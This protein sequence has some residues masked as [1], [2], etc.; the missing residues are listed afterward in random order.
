MTVANIDDRH[1]VR[2]FV[3]HEHEELAAGIE[4]IHELGEALATLPADQRTAGIQRVLHWVDEDVRP[5]M[6]WEE[7][8]LFPLIDDR[9]HTPW[10]TRVARF[11]HR[12]IADQAERLHAHCAYGS[13]SPSRVSTTLLADLSGLEAL[14]RANIEREEQLLL[15]VLDR[16]GDRWTP[17]WRD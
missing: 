11:D 9:A 15:P 8:W 7:A 17:E 4:R 16:A 2:G 13:A 1:G 3:E 10:A 14:L 6:A 12:Q 5:H